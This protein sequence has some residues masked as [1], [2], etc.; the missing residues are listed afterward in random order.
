MKSW[1][2]GK[3]YISRSNILKTQHSFPSLCHAHSLPQEQGRVEEFKGHL[4][5]CQVEWLFRSLILWEELVWKERTSLGH[6]ELP[7]LKW[8]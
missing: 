3:P 1:I 8:G 5:S 4:C 6:E 2:P 7:S